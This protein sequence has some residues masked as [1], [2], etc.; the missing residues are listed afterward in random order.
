MDDDDDRTSVVAPGRVNLIGDHTDYT[1]GYC[2]PIAIDRTVEIALTADHRSRAVELFSEAVGSSATVPIDVEDVASCEPEWARY[3]AAIV[4]RIKPAH[5]WNGT[6]RSTIPLGSGLSSSAALEVAV[7]LALGGTSL[8][9]LEL[10]RLCQSAEHEARG[11]PTGLL[12]QLA[13]ISGVAGHALLIDCS[14]FSVEPRPLPPTEA[15]EV[16][17]I[18]GHPRTLGTTPY[19]TRVAQCLEVETLIGPLRE[20][21]LGD[22]ESIDDETLRRRARHVVTENARVHAFAAAMDRGDLATA[23]T[24][25]NDSHHSLAQDYE[26][27]TPRIDAICA[28]LRSIPGT[29]G[30]RITGGGWGGSIVA[31]AEPGVLAERGWVVRAADGAS[32]R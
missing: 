23:G 17:V 22:I 7:A 5:G 21:T 24:I 25:M 20:A 12:D 3:V 18:P 4:K 16:V 30:A 14:T 28:E 10:A 31:L 15:V 19:S 9:S 26:S 2:L 29:F 27:S 8:G 1:G 32:V 6:V 13:S 11:V